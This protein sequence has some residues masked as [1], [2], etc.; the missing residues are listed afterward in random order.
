MLLF[1]AIDIKLKPVVAYLQQASRRER[2]PAL[3][4]QCVAALEQALTLRDDAAFILIA[5]A[6]GLVID[7]QGYSDASIG[8]LTQAAKRAEGCGE[9]GEKAQLLHLIGRAYYSRAEYRI[10]LDY[11]TDGMRV[12]EQGADPI[13]RSWCK[14]GIGQICDALEAPALA[15]KIF[16]ELGQALVR[17]DGSARALPIAQRP[18]FAMRMRELRVVNTV[19]LGVNELRLNLYEEALTNFRNA[20]VLAHKE[21]MVDIAWECQ[22]RIAEAAFLQGQAKIALEHLETT[23]KPLEDCSHHWGLASLYLL[24][25]Q[26][27]AQ[28][29]QHDYALVSLGHARAAAVLANAKHMSMRIERETAVVAELQ[30]DLALAVASLKR[31][32]LLQTELDRSAKSQMLRDLQTLSET[33][34]C[35]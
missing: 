21:G 35:L 18:R 13:S 4:D 7:Q 34:A 22:V 30:G 15:V 28:L 10:A 27:Q 23:Q 17:L 31:A 20:Q 25:A 1:D 8:W 19:N 14:L 3:Y 12:A 33:Q 6:F 16:T 24:R 26:C 5:Q 9:L 2:S 29:G 32:Y 11:W